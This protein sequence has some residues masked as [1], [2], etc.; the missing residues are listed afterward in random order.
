MIST[1]GIKIANGEFYPV[2]KENSGEKRRLVLTTVQDDQPKLY[3]NLYRSCSGSMKGALYIGSLL[4]KNIKPKSRGEASIELII[5]STTEGEIIASARDADASSGKV[6][7][8]LSV[9]LKLMDENKRKYQREFAEDYRYPPPGLL[10]PQKEKRGIRKK[11]LICAAVTLVLTG[12]V[13][14]RLFFPAPDTGLS[15]LEPPPEEAEI[16]S[17]N[18]GEEPVSDEDTTLPSVMVLNRVEGPDVVLDAYL[19]PELRGGVLKFFEG[20]TGSEKISEVILSNA[21]IHNIPPALAF[22]L[23]EAESSYTPRAV[24]RSNRNGTV[25]RGLFQLNSATFPDLAA[26]EFFDIDENAKL[27]LGHLRWCLDTAGT[28]VAALAL[29]NAGSGTVNSARTGMTTLNYISRI[30]KNRR[31]IEERFIVEYLDTVH[32]MIAAREEDTPLTEASAGEAVS[33]D[34][35][36][37]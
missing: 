16:T 26:E 1:I 12:F 20:I 24:N 13:I 15:A 21:V 35:A 25:D 22:A 28:E 2:V 8:T 36:V 29:Y 7:Q 34:E 27:G 4:V 23:C 19:D 17:Q 31:G 11:V 9:S 30:L 5:A 37:D 18:H 3:I 32:T 6:P 10:E 33:P 14:Q